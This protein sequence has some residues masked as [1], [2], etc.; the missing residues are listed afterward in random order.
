MS[1]PPNSFTM[2]NMQNDLYDVPIKNVYAW[3][4]S[5]SYN[6][7]RLSM[8]LA[9][10][11]RGLRNIHIHLRAGRS[12]ATEYAQSMA[13]LPNARRFTQVDFMAHLAR[14]TTDISLAVE[15]AQ[16]Q[17]MPGTTVRQIMDAMA[18]HIPFYELLEGEIGV[19]HW[20]LSQIQNLVN[21]GLLNDMAHRGGVRQTIQIK[22][23]QYIGNTGYVFSRESQWPPAPGIV[24]HSP[25]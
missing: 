25:P 21:R 4:T 13:A 19:S 16:V 5:P 20:V 6:E 15:L 8:E 23:V 12:V 10:S 9:V 22:I 7:W 2:R 18:R 17:A 11:V 3:C 14:F 1:F 24:H